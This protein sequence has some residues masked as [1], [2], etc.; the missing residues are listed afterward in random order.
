MKNSP[1]LPIRFYFYRPQT[2]KRHL[3]IFDLFNKRFIYIPSGYFSCGLI[4]WP[5]STL[6][7]GFWIFAPAERYGKRM[8]EMCQSTN[9]LARCIIFSVRFFFYCVIICDREWERAIQKLIPLLLFFLPAFFDRSTYSNTPSKPSYSMLSSEWN[10]NHKYLSLENISSGN[11]WSQYRPNGSFA[12]ENPYW[13]SRIC[14][15]V[16]VTR[17]KKNTR[18]F[19]INGIGVDIAIPN[20]HQL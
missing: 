9:Y 12:F 3:W 10:R 4:F 7:N 20:V 14:E 16:S 17:G 2:I 8:R 19:T 11:F 6:L 18:K 5:K 1:H 13:P 15:C